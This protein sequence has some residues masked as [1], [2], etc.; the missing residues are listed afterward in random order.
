MLEEVAELGFEYAE[1]SHGI[2]VSLVPGILNAVRDGVVKIASLHNFCPLPPSV[3]Y[4]APNI[5]QPTAKDVRERELWLKYTKSTIDFAQQLGADRVVLHGGSVKIFFDGFI[6][7]MLRYRTGKPLLEL[8]ADYY[9]QML[10]ERA[11]AKIHKASR[12]SIQTLIKSLETIIPY[13]QERGIK[14]GI[15]N[16]DGLKELPMDRDYEQILD[17]FGAQETLYYWHDTG[18]S[19]IKEILGIANQAA[20]LEKMKGRTLGIHVKDARNDG[21]ENLAIGEGELDWDHIS[22]YFTS[23]QVITLEVAPDLKTSQIAKSKKLLDAMIE[24]AFAPSSGESL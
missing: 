13:A 22:R 5:Y 9:Y 6:K 3:H 10:V 12:P 1:L 11:L 21:M 19:K 17:Y 14:L 23:D 7:K 15:E 20:Q 16:R 4:A 18:H 2:R 24:K 8:Q